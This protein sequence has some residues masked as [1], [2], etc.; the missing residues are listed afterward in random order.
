LSTK[1]TDHRRKG[2]KE[3]FLRGYGS[4][5]G[6]GGRSLCPFVVLKEDRAH[7]SIVVDWERV[8]GDIDVGCKVAFGSTRCLRKG[9]KEKHLIRYDRH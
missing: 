2:L 5:L 1:R 8:R 9:L 7:A 4:V 3:A 6:L